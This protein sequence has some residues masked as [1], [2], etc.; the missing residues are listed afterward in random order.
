MTDVLEIKVHLFSKEKMQLDLNL[1]FE[2]QYYCFVAHIHVQC[3]AQFMK[4][5][6]KY[7]FICINAS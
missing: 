6:S 2:L 1:L 4:V 3:S 5:A 7:D